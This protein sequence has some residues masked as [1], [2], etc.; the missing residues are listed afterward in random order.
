MQAPLPGLQKLIGVITQ[1]IATAVATD[2]SFQSRS[3]DNERSFERARKL[4]ESIFDHDAYALIDPGSTHSYVATAFTQKI[5]KELSQM[6]C[7]LVI[8]MPVGES[9]TVDQIYKECPV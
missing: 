6:D 4:G 9:V 3:V 7:S 5:D 8:S 2:P 1:A